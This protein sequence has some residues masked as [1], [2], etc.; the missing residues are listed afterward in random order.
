MPHYS[1]KLTR[2]LLNPTGGFLS[3]FTHSVNV[4]QGC[5][6]GKG[7]TT[8]EGCPFCYVRAM[9]IAKYAPHKWGDWV[10]AKVN[11]PE[12]LRREL[13]KHKAA[14][15]LGQLRVFMSTATDPYQGVES[16]LKLTRA[17]LEVFRE[18][19]PGLLVLQTRS[20]LIERDL[21]LLKELRDFL[22]ISLTLE[23]DDEAIRRM[24]TPTSPSVPRRLAALER[25]HN[26]G[27]R[28]QAAVSPMLP[29]DPARFAA[30]LA[31]RCSRALVDTFAGNGMGG[32]RTEALGVPAQLRR[33]GYGAWLEAGPAALLG[34]LRRTLGPERVVFSQ[35]GFNDF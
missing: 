1:E 24:L 10:T 28:V 25:L 26:A 17:V 14:G 15:G 33:L 18:F 29:G 6:F 7:T 9:P 12:I 34:A 5:A 13:E 30:L 19:P 21:D 23:T 20:P 35:E 2:T 8:G 22:W 4:Y 16:R 31:P 27:L 32:K 11:A 3:S